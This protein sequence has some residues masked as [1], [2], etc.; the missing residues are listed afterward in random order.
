MRTACFNGH[1]YRGG[2]Q[3]C[4][5]EV[6]CAGAGVWACVQGVYTP[7]I[8]RQN[9]HATQGRHPPPVNRMTDRCK[10]ITFPELRVR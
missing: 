9:P 2:V 8:Q 7:W 10:N 1:L 6:G 5:S 3:V 4:V